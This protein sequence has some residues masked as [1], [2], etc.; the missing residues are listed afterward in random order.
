[1][2]TLKSLSKKIYFDI[3]MKIFSLL[4]FIF[5]LPNVFAESTQAETEYI[6]I[7]SDLKSAKTKVKKI[8]EK[9]QKVNAVYKNAELKRKNIKDKRNKVIANNKRAEDKM[10]EAFL[11]LRKAAKKEYDSWIE[12]FDTIVDLKKSAS[13]NFAIPKNINAKLKEARIKLEK[14]APKEFA[15]RNKSR[16]EWYKTNDEERKAFSENDKAFNEWIKAYYNKA[17]VERD[18]VHIEF[19]TAFL[20]LKKTNIEVNDAYSYSD[21]RLQGQFS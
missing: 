18:K 17:L 10:I 6:K 9:L 14:D 1:M 5:F 2:L 16:Y 3:S 12:I 20:K 15:E 19:Y 4:F 8:K 13:K 11:K 7:S 21:F